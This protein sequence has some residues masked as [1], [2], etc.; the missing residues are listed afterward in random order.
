MIKTPSDWPYVIFSDESSIW[1]NKC[2]PNSGWVRDENEIKGEKTHGPKLH[3]WGA[4]STRGTVPLEIFEDNLDAVHYLNIFLKKKPYMGRLF[5]EGFIF[6]QDN[7]PK[8]TAD[9][10]KSYLNIHFDALMDWPPCSPDLS[11]IENIW[12]WLKSQLRKEQPRDIEEMRKAI[13]KLWRKITPE[14]LEPYFNSMENR[15]NLLIESNGNK[16]MY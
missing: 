8:H 6:Q 7:D 2:V 9:T 13:I 15:M 4:I 5:P 10:V 12:F 11:P 1:V 14:F 3:V 16:I